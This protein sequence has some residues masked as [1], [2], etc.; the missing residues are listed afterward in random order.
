MKKDEG[1]KKPYQKPRL[2]IIELAAEETLAVGCKTAIG[3]MAVGGL[4]PCLTNGCAG[5]GS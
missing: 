4:P 3:G 5:V 1:L 2:R